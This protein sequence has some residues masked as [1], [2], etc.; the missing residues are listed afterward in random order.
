[1]SPPD[2]CSQH[3][4]LTQ[5][6]REGFRELNKKVDVLTQCQNDS[7]ADLRVHISRHEERERIDAQGFKW[8]PVLGGIIQW[9]AI[10]T[11]T[12]LILLLLAHSGIVSKVFGG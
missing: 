11:M 1:M 12:A 8:S 6:I 7:R 9:A 10:A 3:A 5:E 4:E 2:V